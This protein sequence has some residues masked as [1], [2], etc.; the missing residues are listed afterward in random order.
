MKP[1]GVVILGPAW[2]SC[3]SYEVFKRQMACMH[4]LGYKTYFLAVSPIVQIGN[5]NSY[6]NTYYSQTTDLGADFRG[7]TGRSRI[8]FKHPGFWQALPGLLGS[9]VA[10]MRALNA[11]L[12]S[13][14]EALKEFI[15][16]HEIDTVI[17]HHYFNLPLAR[18]IRTLLPGA[19]LVLETQDVQSNHYMKEKY[20]HPITKRQSSFDENLRDEMDIASEADILIHYN[21]E[22]TATFRANMPQRQHLTV[23]PAFPR[24]YQRLA[25][26]SPPAKPFDFLI[27][28]SANDPNY[29]SICWFLENVWSPDLD[30]RFDLRIA[31]NVDVLLTMYKSPLLGQ[32]GHRFL[33]RVESLFDLYK[34]ARH[35]LLPVSDGQ[36]ISIKTIECLSYGKSI[37]STPLAFRGFIDRVPQALRDEAAGS[38]TQ[39]REKLLACDTLSAPRQDP[40]VSAL[41]EELF[42]TDAQTEIY[43]AL[44][45]REKISQ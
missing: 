11:A 28:A 40:R 35:V 13:I 17:C 1:K 12:M 26:D 43:R 7:H 37:V 14:P 36:G 9:S 23:F 38:A 30:S 18:R 44:M 4:D 8:F 33:G 31:G 27:V 3:G 5:N 39:M 20:R 24:N 32:Y 29:R 2:Y 25:Q 45:S 41:Y 6:W 21:E 15:A 34:N 42:S 22:E 19:Q 10:R 16:A